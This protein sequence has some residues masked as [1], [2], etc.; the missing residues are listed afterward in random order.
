MPAVPDVQRMLPG[1]RAALALAGTVVAVALGGCAASTNSSGSIMI[2]GDEPPQ[3]RRGAVLFRERCSGCH[4]FD[5]AGAQGSKPLGQI[6]GGERTNGPN[7]SVR[8]EER[9]DVLYAIRNGGFSGA[10]M[11]ANIV[12]GQDAEAIADFMAK[13]TG[14]AEPPTGGPGRRDTGGGTSS[15]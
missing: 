9:E 2:A 14:G 11:P 4:T 3:I 6:G 15:N 7:F 12:V 8:R 1:R 10:I 13:Y 5:A